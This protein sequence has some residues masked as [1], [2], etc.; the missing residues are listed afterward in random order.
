MVLTPGLR[1]LARNLLFPTL[2]ILLA[3]GLANATFGSPLSIWT[4]LWVSAVA[5]VSFVVVSTAARSAYHEVQAKSMGARLAPRVKGRW[6]G[7]VD[8]LRYL[9]ATYETGYLGEGFY[10]IVDALGPVFNL[11][12]LWS[13]HIFTVSPEHIQIILATDFDN[14]VKG[15]RFRDAMDSVLGDGVFNS[16]GEMWSFHRSM[17]RPY[18]ARDRVR[19]FE[20][21]DRHAEKTISLIKSRMNDDHAVDFQDLISRFTMDAATEFLFG[22]CV[23]SLSA[24]LPLPYNA[25]RPPTQQVNDFPTA[26]G[27]V[28][29]QIAFRERVGWVWPLLEIFGDRTAKSMK[30]VRQFVDP[31]IR[32][33]VE[34]KKG[35]KE[36]NNV[37]FEGADAGDSDTLLDELL[38]STT[39]S[40]TLVSPPIE[41]CCTAGRETTMNCLT[42]TVYFLAMYPKVAARLRDEIITVVGPSNQPSYDDIKEMK[43]LRAVFNET[44]RLYPPVPFNLRETVKA[45][46]WPSPDPRDKPIYIP[47]GVKIP[48]SVMIMQRR[49][50]LW[51]PDANEFDPERFLDERVNKYFVAN[52]FQFLPFNGGPRICLGQQF[53]YNEMS[54]ILIRLLQAFSSISLDVEACPPHGRVPEDWA[55][56]AGR[57]GVEQFIPKAHLTMY[58]AGGL[59]VKMKEA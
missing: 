38:N 2:L 5:A 42:I 25:A 52:P 12:F 6:P 45:T 57:K 20:I 18:F 11:E 17:T 33:A 4:A 41:N 49:A 55:G 29:L 21:F 10:E 1:F 7:N 15:A 48:Y 56:R 54:F 9:L 23:D 31:I 51:G 32:D 26:F 8:V 13:S 35:N 43:Y 36:V 30:T 53:A 44:L 47:A 39:G 40:H 34:R 59:W 27:D 28:M 14:Y 3:R 19:H 50:D 37:E 58:T 24:V 22:T 46:T 16:D